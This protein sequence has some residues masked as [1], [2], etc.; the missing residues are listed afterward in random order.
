MSRLSIRNR[1]LLGMHPTSISII[2][3]PTIVHTLGTTDMYLLL[4]ESMANAC[5]CV[6]GEKEK[7]CP[8][9]LFSVHVSV[10]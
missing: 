1:N 10:V 3:Y 7:S 5:T 8:G 6:E 9:V 4:F 2:T